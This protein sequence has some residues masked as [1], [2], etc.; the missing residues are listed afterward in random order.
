MSGTASDDTL[1]SATPPAAVPFAPET[2]VGAGRYR[3]VRSIAAGAMGEVFEAEDLVIGSRIA[4]KV[5]HEHLAKSTHAVARL[6]R[7]IALARKVTHSNVCRVHDVGEH[8]GRVFLTMELLAGETLADRIRRGSITREER[9]RIAAQMVAGLAALHAAGVVHRDFKPANVVLVDGRVV[10]TDFGLARGTEVGER[11]LTAEGAFLGTPG[12]MA[13]EQVEGREATEASDIYAL[14]VV[15]YELAT[16]EP[17]FRGDTAMAVATARLTEQPARPSTRSA[18]LS[19]SWDASIMRCLARTPSERFQR[20]EDVLRPIASRPRGR[21]LVL[22][23]LAALG[24]AIAVVAVLVARR[25]GSA[26]ELPSDPRARVA[27]HLQRDEPNAALAILERLIAER[28]DDPKLHYWIALA[29]SDLAEVERAER[30]LK[31]AHDK[32]AG[33]PEVER[34]RI[35]QRHKLD[36]DG[37]YAGALEIAD[38]LERLAPGDIEDGLVRAWLQHRAGRTVDALAT[39]AVLRSGRGANDPR[40]DIEE[41]RFVTRTDQ[42]RGWNLAQRALATAT[43][44][45]APQQE[46]IAL[47]LMAWTDAN[48]GRLAQAENEIEGARRRFADA[49]N[50]QRIVNA[51][52]ALAAV[53]FFRGKYRE[54]N[55]AIK[56]ATELN[57]SKEPGSYEANLAIG[58]ALVGEIEAADALYATIKSSDDQMVPVGRAWVAELRGDLP[59]ARSTLDQARQTISREN[60]FASVFCY[61]RS[62]VVHQ[63]MGNLVA[64]RADLEAAIADSGPAGM[65]QIGSQ[66]R[67]ALARVALLE[68]NAR[69]AEALARQGLD[70]QRD[71]GSVAGVG[72]GYAVL[73]E[74]QL[75]SNN[76]SA[77][78]TTLAESAKVRGAI[79]DPAELA[80]LDRAAELAR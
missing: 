34:L 56:T 10:I 27:Y 29:C 67:I 50:R 59:R 54:A 44:R 69:S 2:R 60:K 5:L 32:R 68:G 7:E 64:A 31:L 61:W 43:R 74:A 17:P 49:G 72:F 51:L 70:E 53:Q 41:A 4:L 33:L 65:L 11:D 18:G 75:A 40:V 3:I 26:E 14:G 66:A 6:R 8:E 38:Q 21:L 45:R 58:M 1:E 57:I 20:V 9:E 48:L 37:D 39:L 25:S 13:P 36:V 76:P 30:H 35:E 78:H 79:Q 42:Q 77:A 73:V 46:A 16:G 52:N 55:A 22:G 28:P 47:Q 12:Y 23:V 24:V 63:R 19:A 62:G 80:E 15:L 71:H